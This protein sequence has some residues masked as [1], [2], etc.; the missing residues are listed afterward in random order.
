MITK[1]AAIAAL[2]LSLFV[3]AAA[4]GAPAPAATIPAAAAVSAVEQALFDTRAKDVARIRKL[5]LA[6]TTATPEVQSSCLKDL[7]KAHSA[8]AETDK[9]DKAIRARLAAIRKEGKVERGKLL[10]LIGEIK[11]L[12]DGNR[13]NLAEYVGRLGTLEGV[14][15]GQGEDVQ[16][17]KER[18][19]GI[20]RRQDHQDNAIKDV[21]IQFAQVS[22]KL[23]TNEFAFG[24]FTGKG[25]DVSETG[26]NAR[27][28]ARNHLG[29]GWFAS[30]SL[31][32]GDLVDAP[33]P[34]SAVVR[35]GGQFSVSGPRSALTLD[36]GVLAGAAG[37][38]LAANPG[39]VVGG[40]AGFTL[41]PRAWY[42]L[43]IG[44]GADLVTGRYTGINASLNISFSPLGELQI[45]E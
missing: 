45:G 20:E 44:V 43:G 35:A 15:K 34:T 17:L 30:A 26:F 9:S 28:G 21:Q 5:E 22:S 37:T 4:H 41:R 25:Y 24:L 27:F 3:T 39:F 14:V 8:K 13:K 16:A 38:S 10:D 18:A 7:S 29:N 32:A 42:G 11:G 1:F 40:T 19:T 36:V 12:E 2:F 31:G 33:R 23:W 6:A